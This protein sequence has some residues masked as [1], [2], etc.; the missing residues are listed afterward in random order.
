MNYSYPQQQYIPQQQMN[1]K[2]QMWTQPTPQ[3]RPVSS[4][5][6]VRATM[7]DFDGSVFYFPDLANRRIYTKQINLDGTAILRTYEL[8]ENINETT[9]SYITREEFESVIQQLKESFVQTCVQPQE[10]SL[11]IEKKPILNF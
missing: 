6:E 1:Y 4:I 8:K 3:V 5:E 11:P 2:P 9:A 10:S 7:I